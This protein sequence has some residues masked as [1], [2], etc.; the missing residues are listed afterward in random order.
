LEGATFTVVESGEDIYL[1]TQPSQPT[2]LA[3]T[4]T[5][6]PTSVGLGISQTYYIIITNKGPTAA[7]VLAV[8]NVLPAGSVTYVGSSPGGSQSGSEVRWRLTNSLAPNAVTSVTVTV[9]FGAFG[10][11]TNAAAV[12]PNAGDMVL[13]DNSASLTTT[14]ACTP[15]VGP[16]ITAADHTGVTNELMEFTVVSSDPGCYAP[17]LS[18]TGLPAG[19]TFTSQVSGLTRTG[20]FSWTPNALQAGTH[21]VRFIAED[22]DLISTSKTIRVYVQT[23]EEGTNGSGV[24]ESQIDWSPITNITFGSS[25]NVTVTWNSVTGLVYDVYASPNSM[26][27]GQGFSGMTWTR[28]VTG[29]YAM[30]SITFTNVSGNASQMYYQVV[31]GGMP[32]DGF[33]T[34]GIVRPRIPTS[35]SLIAPPFVDD[36]LMSGRFGS[37]L[38]ARLTASGTPGAGDEVLLP[39][40]TRLSLYRESEVDPNVKWIDTS[41]NEYTTPLPAGSGL[42]VYHK[43]STTVTGQFSGP[44]RNTGVS[45]NVIPATSSVGSYSVIS[46][47]EGRHVPLQSAFNDTLEGSE[48]F[49]SN[50]DQAAD[51]VILLEPVT[52]YHRYFYSADGV[53]IDVQTFT[54]TSI[55]LRPGQ[56]YIY[57]RVPDQPALKA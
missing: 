20:Y 41:F 2:D 23:G 7:A 15:G 33:G 12:M 47:S 28:I 54:P 38:A 42:Y 16:I 31:G 8:T 29:M 6:Y 4:M 53:W 51:Q 21:L 26:I 49:G 55:Y 43:A 35:W 9:Q 17:A 25:G 5:N 30:G 46:L 48:P 52:G 24:P 19:V 36:R 13:A 18:A 27:K 11:Y 39:D 50:D 10:D 44:V 1:R 22:Q 14:V 40:G 3:M 34:W 57:Y 37:N 45:T 56:A 32:R